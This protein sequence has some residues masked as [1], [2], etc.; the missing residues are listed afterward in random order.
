MWRTR[1]GGRTWT[2]LLGIGTTFGTGMA[3][4]SAKS[5]YVVMPSFRGQTGGYLMR[6]DDGGK[7]WAPQLVTQEPIGQ[8][9]I[10]AGGGI[11]YLLAGHASFLSTRSG[12]RFGDP[13]SLTIR[14]GKTKLRKPVRIRISGKLSPARGNEEVAV[15]AQI[16]G[17]WST[18]TARAAANGS[19][20]TSWQVRRGANAFVAQWAGD[21]RLA[22]D[23]STVLTVRVGK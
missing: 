9:G 16:N 14:T 5:G 7:T 21:D 20:T 4:S 6:T 19:F 12:G 2:Q 8:F 10:A 15:S 18:Q 13:S 11:D 23:G 3:F 17:R 22:G 1:N